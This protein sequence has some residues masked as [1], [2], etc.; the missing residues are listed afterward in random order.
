MKGRN[1]VLKKKISRSWSHFLLYCW[2]I[3]GSFHGWNKNSVLPNVASTETWRKINEDC[4]LYPSRGEDEQPTR[5]G[6]TEL[7]NTRRSF[8]LGVLLDSLLI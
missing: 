7:P 6:N 2:N 5:A 4:L 1:D 3:R 8:S